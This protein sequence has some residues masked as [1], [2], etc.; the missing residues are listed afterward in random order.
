MNRCKPAVR[1]LLL[2]CSMLPQMACGK[3]ARAALPAP[4]ALGVVASSGCGGPLQ[5]TGLRGGLAIQVNGTSRTYAL[6]VPPSASPSTTPLAL[7]LGYH[8]AGGNGLDFSTGLQLE[9]QAA[10]RAIFVYPDG[11]GGSWDTSETGADVQMFDALVA[12]IG[13]AYCIDKNRIFATGFS[14]GASMTST[15]GC[16][17]GDA[18]RAIAIAAGGILFPQDAKCKRGLAAWMYVGTNDPNISAAY[19]TRDFWRGRDRCGSSSIPVNPD[20]CQGHLGCDPATSVTY[21][22]WAGGHELAPFG[23]SG[24]WAFFDTFH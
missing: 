13:P 3:M 11:V 12:T 9:P 1:T 8:G 10:G 24:T 4:P 15:I 17:R 6:S 7:I 5:P 14:Y 2:C 23:A 16:F 19:V 21:C 20:P 18:V 22:Q